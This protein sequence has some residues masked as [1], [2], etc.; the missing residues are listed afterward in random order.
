[1]KAMTPEERD[2][3]IKLGQAVQAHGAAI[4]ELQKEREKSPG[5]PVLSPVMQAP[6]IISK[7]AHDDIGKRFKMD[8]RFGNALSM[9]MDERMRLSVE[10]L[11]E[12]EELFKEYEIIHVTGTYDRSGSTI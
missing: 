1:M 3:M 11:A 6:G 12:M 8:V 5:I 7:I 2:L 10:F 9:S 4:L